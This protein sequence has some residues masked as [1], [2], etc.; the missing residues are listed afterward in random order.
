MHSINKINQ[1]VVFAAVVLGLSACGGGSSKSST[2]AKQQ[3]LGEWITDCIPFTDGTSE[4][5]SMSLVKLDDGSDGFFNGN[6]SYTTN[7]CSGNADVI[8]F[9]GPVLY[10]GEYA[11]SICKA[12]KIDTTLAVITDG[13]TTLVGSDLQQFLADRNLSDKDYD[14]ACKYREQLLLG[15]DTGANE[16]STSANRPVS[17]RVEIPFNTWVRSKQ[18][19]STAMSLQNNLE[20]IRNRLQSLN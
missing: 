2:S 17:M 11:T 1:F 15:D 3:I 9:G 12:E 8:V 14:L 16:G 20:Q 18:A 13:D 10:R 6:S 5:R 4:V 19:K 7:D